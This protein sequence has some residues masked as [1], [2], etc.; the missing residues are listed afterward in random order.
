MAFQ[1]VSAACGVGSTGALLN[2]LLIENITKYMRG[3]E[4][5]R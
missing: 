2:N 3:T 4:P 5:P 1:F